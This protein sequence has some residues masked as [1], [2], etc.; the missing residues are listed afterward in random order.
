VK[1]RRF[2]RR[3][4]STQRRVAG[5]PD[6]LRN[7]FRFLVQP[8]PCALM[9]IEFFSRLRAGFRCAPESRH[10]HHKLMRPNHSKAV[11]RRM[12][13]LCARIERQSVATQ[14]L[15]TTIECFHGQLRGLQQ[16]LPDGI[17]GKAWPRRQPN[18][19]ERAGTSEAAMKQLMV[20]Y[21]TR[22][23]VLVTAFQMAALRNRSRRKEISNH[24][25][26]SAAR[27]C[28]SRRPCIA[29]RSECQPFTR[30]TLTRKVGAK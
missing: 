11:T 4:F 27:E 28:T 19:Q 14:P 1:V 29:S 3:S 17:D 22:H 16:R 24:L 21:S 25:P 26:N 9:N 15:V 12:A 7:P 23:A 30:A 20:R 13:L 5:A 18:R 6:N 2:I 10:R 8:R